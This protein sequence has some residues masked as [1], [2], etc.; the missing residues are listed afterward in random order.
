MGTSQRKIQSVSRTCGE[1]YSRDSFPKTFEYLGSSWAR[2]P[3]SVAEP[4][5][6][7]LS[8]ECICRVSPSFNNLSM[9]W[10]LISHGSPEKYRLRLIA[11]RYRLGPWNTS[12]MNPVVIPIL[13]LENLDIKSVYAIHVDEKARDKVS[14]SEMQAQM[15]KI[16]GFVITIHKQTVNI[17]QLGR[18]LHSTYR[19]KHLHS[20][21]AA[22]KM[23][24]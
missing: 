7:S 19:G 8:I 23:R 11:D 5:T 16:M 17:V 22:K 18:S 12:N 21:S 20:L 2:W 14:R 4:I 13:Q 3:N 9:L 10:G 24:E 6:I 15:R 1:M